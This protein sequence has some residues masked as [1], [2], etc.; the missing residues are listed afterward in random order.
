MKEILYDLDGKISEHGQFR[1]PIT[2]DAFAFICENDI[3]N[4]SETNA[5]GTGHINDTD[6]GFICLENDPYVNNSID[7]PISITKYLLKMIAGW[8]SVRYKEPNKTF[9]TYTDQREQSHTAAW[10]P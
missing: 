4:F 6:D 8:A 5:L 2:D 1:W 10:H 3:Q 9:P 7:W